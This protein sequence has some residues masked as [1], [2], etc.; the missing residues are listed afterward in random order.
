MCD[1]I[2]NLKRQLFLCN[3]I[4]YYSFPVFLGKLCVCVDVCVEFKAQFILNALKFT[5]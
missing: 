2:K 1:H 5:C 3:I 4:I